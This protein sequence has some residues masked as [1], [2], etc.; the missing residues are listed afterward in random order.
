M[1]ANDTSLHNKLAIPGETRIYFSQKR[2]WFR[3]MLISVTITGCLYFMLKNGNY[4]VGL[5]LSGFLAALLVWLFVKFG[6]RAPQI[7]INAKGITT[8]DAGFVT[9]N[10]IHNE[11]VVCQHK[12]RITTYFLEYKYPEGYGQVNINQLDIDHQQLV[13]L[14]KYYRSC[15]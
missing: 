8:I 4:L 10:D 12:G 2:L 15:S 1:N 5:P 6:N 3:A 13:D 11:E 9:W 14:L 7:I